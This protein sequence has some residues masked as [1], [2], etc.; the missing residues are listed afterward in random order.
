MPKID[1]DVERLQKYVYKA[2]YKKNYSLELKYMNDWK[3]KNEGKIRYTK[4][5]NKW[6]N[7]HNIDFIKQINQVSK[8][9]LIREKIKMWNRDLF[10][11]NL[12]IRYKIDLCRTCGKLSRIR[13]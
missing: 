10:N 6:K 13:H 5:Q 3:I 7:K 8:N 2:Q 12:S 11:I 4:S 1:N 9:R